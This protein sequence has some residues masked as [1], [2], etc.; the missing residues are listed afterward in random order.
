MTIEDYFRSEA[1]EIHIETDEY[2]ISVN[3][4]TQYDELADLIEAN[5]SL[6]EDIR[7]L[8]MAYNIGKVF[9]TCSKTTKLAQMLNSEPSFKIT[10]EYTE[11]YYTYNMTFNALTE[12]DKIEEFKSKLE[13]HSDIVT[14]EYELN[15]FRE[16]RNTLQFAYQ[17]HMMYLES[18]KK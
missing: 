1:F 14:L 18:I 12:C 6:I 5:P 2:N 8:W 11:D 16:K 10:L 9:P 4:I 13:V 7:N 17:L 3:V 15:K